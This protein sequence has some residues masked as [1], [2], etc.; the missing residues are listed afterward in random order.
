MPSVSFEYMEGMAYV[1]SRNLVRS[2]INNLVDTSRVRIGSEDRIGW[3][4]D[5]RIG[6]ALCRDLKRENVVNDPTSFKHDT[7]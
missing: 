3:L 2:V 5:A 6:Y 4:E 1:L 7:W